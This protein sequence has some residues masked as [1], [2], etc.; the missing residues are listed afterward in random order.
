MTISL[1]EQSNPQSYK[2]AM[3]KKIKSNDPE[4]IETF[5]NWKQKKIEKTLL[6]EEKN[7]VDTFDY[8]LLIGLR[9]LH[10]LSPIGDTL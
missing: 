6:D 2:A 1:T 9:S 5:Q 10:N 7:K 4:A 3:R 8:S